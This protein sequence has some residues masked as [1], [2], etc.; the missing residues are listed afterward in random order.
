MRR[1]VLA[2][3]AIG[4]CAMTSG[5]SPVAALAGRY[6]RV[7]AI[8]VIGIGGV[9]IGKPDHVEDIVEIVPVSSSAAYIRADF[10]GADEG[11]CSISGLAHA[12][13]SALV[14]HDPSK[15]ADGD[16]ACTITI[17]RIG[18]NLRV[19]D[20]RNKKDPNYAC[21][22]LYCGE[23]TMLQGDLPWS[24]KRPITYMKRLK[25]SSQYRAAVGE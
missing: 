1:N 4:C 8:P 22:N 11:Y 6:S 17:E 16:P 25:A 5:S 21:S 18:K 2:I 13:G 7:C 20:G 23:R 19:T 24:S 12:E 14:Y 15:P 3:V 9:V 10:V